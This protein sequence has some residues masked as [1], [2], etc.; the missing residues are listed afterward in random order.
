MANISYFGIDGKSEKEYIEQ[1]NNQLFNQRDNSYNIINICGVQTHSRRE[2]ELDLICI[3]NKSFI[4]NQ[5]STFEAEKIFEKKKRVGSDFS[6]IEIGDKYTITNLIFSIEIK[7]HSDS[8]I[9]ISGDDIYVYYGNKKD[10]PTSKFISQ[11]T[12]AKDWLKG[13]SP[14]STIYN[15]VPLIYFPN[16][17]KND[18]DIGS[19]PLIHTVI[20]KDS[21]IKDL[22]NCALYHQ[23]INS[24]GYSSFLGQKL[25]YFY[26][27]SDLEK[28]YK[29]MIPSKLE[30]EKLEIIS[31]KIID[32]NKDWVN[33]IGEKPIAFLGKAGTGKTLKLVRLANDLLE[34]FEPV[35]FLTF[36]KALAKDLE[37]L[38]ELQRL[39][40][41]KSMKV[42]TIYKFLFDLAKK[43]ELYEKDFSNFQKESSDIFKD[44]AELVL[45]SLQDEDILDKI[46]STI[47]RE[48]NFVAIDEAQDWLQI[49]RDIII[50]IFNPEH[51]LLAVGTDQCMRSPQIA[52]WKG[53]FKRL[54]NSAEQVR[55]NTS[56]RLKTNLTVFNNSLANE[57]KF[58]WSVK[59]NNE[60]SGGEITFFNKPTEEIYK[61]FL[62]EIDNDGYHP[63]DFLLISSSYNAKTPKNIINNI[64]YEFWDG[65]GIEDRDKMI[66]INDI[67]GVSLESCR[68]LEG[69]SVLVLDIDY[70]WKWC[71]SHSRRLKNIEDNHQL[72][73][74]SINI[75]DITDDNLNELPEWFLIPFTRAKHRLL[76]QMPSEGKLKDI[77]MKVISINRDFINYIDN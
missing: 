38:T 8:G 57:L 51:I 2:R 21:T 70:W 3:L 35:L 7:S 61:N 15:I 17:S 6:N 56:L 62:S 9:E 47:F 5:K 28:Y 73:D 54:K 72:F 30:Q 20:F 12:S 10:N 48:F 58:N 52:N 43:F 59:K 64:G 13:A 53:D 41:A 69:W 60:I 49:E 36:N 55:S 32:K 68:G 71:I 40:E 31:K 14:S 44:I 19:K 26:L 77:F 1:L 33:S 45:E 65:I 27:L 67:R 4:Q 50:K 22:I 37:R 76:L 46:R 11:A 66:G 63:V 42:W 34:D 23:G 75:K 25:E 74:M 24:T 18:I 39:T 16:I 29:K